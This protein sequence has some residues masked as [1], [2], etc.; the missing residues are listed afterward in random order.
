MTKIQTQW[1]AN[2]SKDSKATR[3]KRSDQ[4]DQESREMYTYTIGGRL[5]FKEKFDGS[6]WQITTGAKVLETFESE[7][8]GVDRYHKLLLNKIAVGMILG[9][10]YMRENIGGFNSAASYSGWVR[11]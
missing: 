11:I 6:C 1:W 10:A 4:V 7:E 5:S 2:S 8:A 3:L 9:H